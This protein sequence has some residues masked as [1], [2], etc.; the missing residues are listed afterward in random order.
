MAH[1]NIRYRF[2][3]IGFVIFILFQYFVEIC[4]A[5]A[6]FRD[7]NNSIEAHVI[8]GIVCKV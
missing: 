7:I 2:Q 6:S 5:N 3:Q 1:S 4:L 8:H